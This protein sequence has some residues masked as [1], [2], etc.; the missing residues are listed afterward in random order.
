VTSSRFMNLKTAQTTQESVQPKRSVLKQTT[1][2]MDTTVAVAGR[3]WWSQELVVTHAGLG[4][5][6]VWTR[7]TRSTHRGAVLRVKTR[8]DRGRS[9]KQTSRPDAHKCTRLSS[10]VLLPPLFFA[11]SPEMLC[12]VSRD[13][14]FFGGLRAH[15]RIRRR[16]QTLQPAV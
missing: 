15:K 11:P 6:R 9:G 4:G 12:V 2:D 3:C 10:G 16:V 1:K 13:G 5:R 8:Q 7:M 14:K